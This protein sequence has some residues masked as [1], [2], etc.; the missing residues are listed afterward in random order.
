MT[1]PF[2]GLGSTGGSPVVQCGVR[3]SSERNCFLLQAGWRFALLLA[4][5]MSAMGDPA[6]GAQAAAATSTADGTEHNHWSLQPL[7]SHA[8]PQ[9]RKRDWP[10]TP[11][12]Q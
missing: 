8:P 10:R 3:A 7:Q 12:D 6:Q 1:A 9:I 5:A 11:I 4:L 2:L